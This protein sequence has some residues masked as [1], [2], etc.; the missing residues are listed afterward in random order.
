MD[1]PPDDLQVKPAC[2]Y[3]AQKES[4]SAKPASP[5]TVFS[6]L[7][8]QYLSVVDS[9]GEQTWG[10]DVRHSPGTAQQSVSAEQR[11]VHTRSAPCRGKRQGRP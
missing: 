8:M 1:P 6:Q 5:I 2:A 3:V 9:K 7:R 4:A 11:C 10:N